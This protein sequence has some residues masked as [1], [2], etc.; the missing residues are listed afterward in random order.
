[1]SDRDLNSVCQWSVKLFH[2][3]FFIEEEKTEKSSANP[4]TLCVFECLVLVVVT[5]EGGLERY[6]LP[7]PGAGNQLI[8]KRLNV[9]SVFPLR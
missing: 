2:G 9:S 1:M 7:F 8:S 6:H 5:V 3:L 4:F